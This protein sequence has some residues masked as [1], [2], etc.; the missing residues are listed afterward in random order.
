[1]VEA[2]WMI[3]IPDGPFS[4]FG[5][6]TVWSQAEWKPMKE[7]QCAST[8]KP[9][10]NGN[11]SPRYVQQGCGWVGNKL[12]HPLKSQIRKS[13]LSQHVLGTFI[14]KTIP[15]K[16][17]ANKYGNS[18]WWTFLFSLLLKRVK[19]KYKRKANQPLYIYIYKYKLRYIYVY[20]FI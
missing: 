13:T 10:P 6:H 16:T 4:R 14:H 12:K 18:S 11:Y 7:M 19:Q 2:I 3:F 5:Y 20:V 8:W 15:L 17:K 9:N 1:M